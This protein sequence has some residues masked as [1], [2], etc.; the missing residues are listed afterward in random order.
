MFKFSDSLVKEKYT[1]T[2]PVSSSPP[3]PKDPRQKQGAVEPL[4][5]HSSEVHLHNHSVMEEQQL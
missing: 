2:H 4:V 5:L 1:H 3:P